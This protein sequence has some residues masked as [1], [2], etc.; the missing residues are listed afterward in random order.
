M[1]AG[2]TLDTVVVRRPG[3]ISA[4]VGNETAAMNVDKGMYYGFDDIGT[5]IWDIVG[6]PCSVSSI[7]DQ[8]MDTYDVD[9]DTCR[10]DVNQFLGV[11][12]DA[13]LLEIVGP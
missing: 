3:S 13:E 2:L 5:R 12:L 8:L 6:S 4:P 11:L 7:C 1:T 9:A 10:R